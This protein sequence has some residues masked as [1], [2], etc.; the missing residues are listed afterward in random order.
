ML[1]ANLALMEKDFSAAHSWVEAAAKSAPDQARVQAYAAK[2][3]L[4]IA[5]SEAKEVTVAQ[6]AKARAYAV[7][8]LELDPRCTLATAVLAIIDD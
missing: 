2:L 5:G 8:A 7:R 3:T 4:T 6:L 1:R